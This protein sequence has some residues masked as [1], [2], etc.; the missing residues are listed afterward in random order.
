MASAVDDEKYFSRACHIL[1]HSKHDSQQFLIL[2]TGYYTA[3]ITGKP[4]NSFIFKRKFILLKRSTIINK[5]MN[6]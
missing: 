1:F 4:E 2:N 3:N 5:V 6:N